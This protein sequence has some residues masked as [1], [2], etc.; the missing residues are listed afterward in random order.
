MSMRQVLKTVC[1]ISIFAGA[2]LLLTPE[3]SAR[4][5]L[6][7]RSQQGQTETKE[8]VYSQSDIRKLVQ[9]EFGENH[10]MVDVARCESSF[11][12]YEQ[13]GDVL[14]NPESDAI[15]IFQILEGLHERPADELGFDIFTTEGNIG[16]ARKLYDSFGLQ[17]WSPS[18]LCWD[19]GSIAETN[20][21]GN[22]T[23]TAESTRVPV[24]VRSDGEL[25]KDVEDVRPYLPANATSSADRSTDD[26]S[27]DTPK[28]ITKKLV[29]GVR[30]PQVKRLQEL[31]NKLGYRLSASGPG[32][33]GE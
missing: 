31:L 6:T 30:D 28:I 18:S 32:S 24:R 29:S 23:E 20:L 27:A 16:Y 10:P 17:P 25:E 2:F 14:R 33:P 3:V 12:Q 8:T 4:G 11:R 19:D 1:V 13:D 22:K 7:P 5:L 15:G 26:Q 21:S 9:N